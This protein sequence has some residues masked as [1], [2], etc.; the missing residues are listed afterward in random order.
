MV[1]YAFISLTLKEI[2]AGIPHDV[3]ALI[4]YSVLV[5][6]VSF[7]WYGSRSRSGTSSAA[8]PDSRPHG[9]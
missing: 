6:F 7:I 4:A 5:A 1:P 2:I 3:G 9:E 8:A